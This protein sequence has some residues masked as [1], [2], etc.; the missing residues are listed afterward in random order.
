MFF[1]SAL[2]CGVPALLASDAVA[3]TGDKQLQMNIAWV[4]QGYYFG[5]QGFLVEFLGIS[6]EVLNRMPHTR[7][8]QYVKL[9]SLTI[10]AISHRT[11]GLLSKRV[12]WTSQT[13][14]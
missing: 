1:I 4:I 3:A 9:C 5:F 14:T 11:V 10:A 7:L 6:A 8:Q 12:P 13:P 2:W